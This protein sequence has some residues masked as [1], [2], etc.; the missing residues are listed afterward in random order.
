MARDSA[1][2]ARQ[3]CAA[4][5]VKSNSRRRSR[6][7]VQ[8][9]E[10]RTTPSTFIVTSA[11]DSG[12]G[13]LRDA[14]NLANGSAGADTI[15]FDTS[16]VFATP[17]TIDLLTALPSIAAELTIQGPG[18]AKLT[19]ERDAAAANFRIFTFIGDQFNLSGFTITGGQVSNSDGGAIL[20]FGTV[21]LDSMVLTGNQ[22]TS[23]HNGGAVAIESTGSLVVRNSTFSGNSAGKRGGAIALL[24][25]NSLNITNSTL[26]GN[27]TNFTGTYQGF[28][29]GGAIFFQGTGTTSSPITIVNTT[30]ANNT[31]TGSG[32]GFLGDNLLGE[33]TIQD[34]TIT[35]N[36][37]TDA[38]ATYGGGGI[39][40]LYGNGN[41]TIQNSIVSGNTAATAANGPDI[42]SFQGGTVEVDYSA[43]GDP[44]NG[45]T[46]VGSHNL[47]GSPAALGLGPLADNGGPTLTEIPQAGS[48]L[49]DAGSNALV[50]AGLNSDQRGFGFLRTYHATVDIGSVE[51]QPVGLPFALDSTTP[52]TTPGGSTYNFTVTYWDPTG[53]NQGIK[54]NTVNSTPP[55]IIVTDPNGNDVPVTT[56]NISPQ[57][58]APKIVVTYQI[59]A[60]GG[61]WAPADDGIYTVQVRAN[62]VKDE[63]GNFVP[64]DFLDPI[65]I[66]MPR[67]LTVTSAAD[68]G[69]GTLRDALTQ[70]ELPSVDTI[71]FDP[72]V[73]NT[74]QTIVLL[75]PLPTIPTDGGDL[76]ITGPGASLLTVDAGSQFRVLDSQAPN[77]TLSGFAVTGGLATA[78][79]GGGLKSTGSVTL[80]HMVFTGNSATAGILSF[81]QG[82]GGAVALDIGDGFL[83]VED[84]TISGN[85]ADLNGGGIFLRYSVFGSLLVEN[86]TVSGNTT[87]HTGQGQGY[88]GGGGIFLAGAPSHT[89]PPDFVPDAFTIRNS[90]IA[91]NSSMGSG[92]GIFG[93]SLVG[94]VRIQDSTISGNSAV[95]TGTPVGN[96]TVTFG[97]GGVGAIFGYPALSLP[98]FQILNT[99][100]SGNTNAG[101]E[102]DIR[103]AYPVQEYYSLIGDSTGF[104]LT[105]GSTGNL[106]AGTDPKLGPLQDNGGPT[107][108]MAPL[109]GSPL[110]NAGN[111]G[112][113]FGLTVDQRGL[114]RED[115][116]TSLVDIGAVEAQPATVTIA[117]ATGQAN[118]T[119]NNSAVKFTVVFDQPVTGFDASGID[120]SGSS[121][122][123]GT[124]VANV[125]ADSPTTYTV[126]VTGITAD[127]NVV[128]AVKAGTATVGINATGQPNLPSTTPASVTVDTTK[129]TVTVAAN[130]GPTHPTNTQPVTF[131]VQFS[132]PV[133]GFGASAVQLTSSIGDPLIPVVTPGPQ[134]SYQVAVFGMTGSST[135]TA[136]IPAGAVT[137]LA[138]NPN[139][140]SNGTGNIDV[141]DITPPT[142]TIN[143]AA[144]QGDPAGGTSVKFD[145]VFSE[146]VVGFIG[147]EVDLS[148]S[149]APGVLAATVTGTGPAY[150]VTV[151][152]MTGGG[153]V[154]ASIPGAVVTDLAGNLN[155]PS[156]STD[157]SVT[158]VHS[159]NLHF[160]AATYSVNE[161][162]APQLTVTVQR[163]DGS[164]GALDVH[165]A[166]ANGTALAGTDYTDESGDLHW[167][168][169]NTADQTFN[170]PILDDGGLH[171]DSSFTVSLSN[172]SLPG[173]IGTPGTATI[174]I[175]EE[176]LLGFT[177]S[178]FTT[179]ESGNG[180]DVVKQITVSRQGGSNAAVSVNYTVTAGTA[181]AGGDYSAAASGTLSWAAGDTADKT[182]DVTIHDD[183]VN[184]GKETILLGL[185]SPSANVLLGTIAATL[186][187]APSDGI[188]ISAAAKSPQV[189]LPPDANGNIVTI[190]LGGK[191]GSFTYFLTNGAVPVSEIDLNGTVST[192][193]TLSITVKKARGVSGTPTATIGEIDGIG[194]AGLKT[195]SLGKANLVGE[196]IVGDGITFNGFVGSVTVGDVENGADIVLNG[197]ATNPRGVPLSTRITAGQILGT[198]AAP[199][200]ITVAA[201]LASLSAT[202]V[203]NGTITAPSV[204]SIT[205]K[206]KA[207]T[208]TTPAI[209]GDF[210]SNLTISGVGV[211]PV[212][213]KALKSLKVAGS[214][215]GSTISVGG[216]V[217]LVSVGSFLSS[218]LFVGF[219]PTGADP[220]AGT[221]SGKFTAG[222]F[223]VKATTGGFAHSYV[224]ATSIKNVTLASADTANSGTMF[225]F[226]FH[227]SAGGTFGGLTVKNPPLTYNKTIGG[228]QPLQADFE[229]LKS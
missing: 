29:G 68:S 109:A 202:A 160:S 63:D 24:H 130:N 86:S 157:N 222:P 12:T 180:T 17:Q 195:L 111:N 154:Q 16:G 161:Q 74:P 133:V 184:E 214:V 135:V 226:E 47:T 116:A 169:G 37:S 46:L 136:I 122:G 41:L 105:S 215:I 188:T 204:G 163:T 88:F 77:L 190:R 121:P 170:I 108:T 33:L 7:V 38:V 167:A 175:N 14:I 48:P 44:T 124:L 194:T 80:D 101:G 174:N 156:T 43:L 94:T 178:T 125:T 128:A 114:L 50:P 164:D 172:I 8:T 75:S 129:P 64:N 40:D 131:T 139:V 198:P 149:T 79:I 224:V 73:F 56:V 134:N 52:L 4:R 123:M 138:G 197:T 78:D 76:T 211:D 200:D 212:K 22:A 5:R 145:V 205:V 183:Q 49:I 209:A 25:N 186:I 90:T 191:L 104:T 165:Y 70:A 173:A 32:G 1:R 218:D 203:G 187:I 45:F 57:N 30:I 55:A 182:I 221:F 132:E 99:V 147:S 140:A 220:F 72:T 176:A 54:F 199:S 35:G 150:T 126:T 28:Y 152:G 227:G 51:V 85:S 229:V 100:V 185:T 137:D 168:A 113:T 31:T 59:N 151:T 27:T 193:S 62:Q 217:G 6:L 20:A 92:G 228:T 18:A 146:P 110:L 34:S 9:L 10:D 201:P 148:Q 143:Q 67:T 162:G 118:P 91:N 206:G 127:G 89:P 87:T 15:Q 181:T 69:P 196:G 66:I 213:G 153:T 53:T 60:P 36:A 19:V 120:L 192:K 84:S 96:P 142:V 95:A 117:P 42:Y 106:P 112:L 166:T 2:F 65:E 61:V 144:T 210:K 58:D 207:K 39:C 102:P 83:R 3:L 119:N 93:N 155:L 26:S 223:L 98:T 11:A 189:T 107:Q 208:K 97:G 225:G 115:P 219:S 158:F 23:G 216:N 179:A 21:T 82:G 171:P 13:T 71:T 159:G 103:A 177:S 81:D 141:Y